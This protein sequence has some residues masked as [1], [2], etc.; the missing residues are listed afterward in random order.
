LPYVCL[1]ARGGERPFWCVRISSLRQS[2]N[3]LTRCRLLI[4]RGFD[5]WVSGAERGP[6]NRFTILASG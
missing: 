5:V 4:L 2:G 6:K 1:P 3:A